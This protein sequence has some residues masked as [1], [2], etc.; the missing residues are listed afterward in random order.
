MNNFLSKAKKFLGFLS[1]GARVGN[2][3]APRP[4]EASDPDGIDWDADLPVKPLPTLLD[5]MAD[6]ADRLVVHDDGG[7]MSRVSYLA[8]APQPKIGN[9]K[10]S[11]ASAASKPN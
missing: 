1:L 5:A 2:T 9:G 7:F 3:P 4:W 6:E 11:P 8:P 10:D